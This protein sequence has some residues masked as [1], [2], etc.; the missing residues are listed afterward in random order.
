LLLQRYPRYSVAGR[1]FF[2]PEQGIYLAFTIVGPQPPI[3][4]NLVE[5]YLH[6]QSVLAGVSLMIRTREVQSI[7]VYIESSLCYFYK[8]DP[9]N[10]DK[11]LTLIIYSGIVWC[12][13]L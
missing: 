11:L 13:K 10:S 7:V 8:H 12:S 9:C 1:G 6:A 5:R 2:T 4:D 3:N